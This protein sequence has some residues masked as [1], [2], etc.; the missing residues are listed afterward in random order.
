[1]QI[2]CSKLARYMVCA[3]YAHLVV[4]EPEAGEPAREG[5]AAGEYLQHL[6]ENRTNG[7]AAS[8][9][10]IYTDDIKFY[11]MGV[12]ENI[13]GR[14]RSEV[15]CEKRIDWQTRSGIWIRGQYDASFV[16]EKGRLCIE[17]LKYGWALVEVKNNWQLLGYAI[18]EVIRRGQAFNE[19]V[20]RIHQPRPHHEDGP[21]REWVITYAELLE[22][23]EII[24]KRMMELANGRKDFQTSE[25]C[26]YC[27]GTA[28][29]CPAFSRAFYNAIEVSYTS[30]QDSLTEKEI[31]FQITQAKR[32]EEI[33]KIKLDSL[34]ELGTSRIKAGKII[35]GYVQAYRY[36]DRE[37]KAGIGPEAI[38]V[39][40]G[41]DV[42]EKKMMSPAKAEKLGVKKGLIDQ[43]TSRKIIG[44]KLEKGDSTSI[45]DKAFGTNSPTGGA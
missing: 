37:W 3:G 38:K 8:N 30:P 10:F 34:M 18:G 32:A 31:A 5:T 7:H 41:K 6:L 12:Y 20:L 42:I 45:A 24:E 16:D 1:M 23:K 40:T 4:E 28:E 29:A 13:A 21:S 39:M 2:R 43:L 27:P 14:A 44:V 36:S 15:L 9:G 25:A 11:A 19:I 22:Y 33:I 35:P 26:K 17:D